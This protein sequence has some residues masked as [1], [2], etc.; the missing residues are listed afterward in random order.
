MRARTGCAVRLVRFDAA[1]G[2]EE[3]P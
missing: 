1:Q 3:L 2:M